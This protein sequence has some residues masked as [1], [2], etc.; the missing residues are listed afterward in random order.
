M[1]AL[2]NGKWTS[3]WALAF[4][5]QRDGLVNQESSWALIRALFLTR[6]GFETM[7][8]V[9][10]GAQCSNQIRLFVGKSLDVARQKNQ[11]EAI[12]RVM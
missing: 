8:E 2:G 4:M 3:A 6:V 11:T 10:D 12:S 9:N 7:T 1:G 5:S